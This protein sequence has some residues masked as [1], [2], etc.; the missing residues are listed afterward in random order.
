M[1]GAEALIWAGLGSV[2]LRVAALGR[3]ANRGKTW[4]MV[5]PA[6][7]REV[8]ATKSAFG[9]CRS[10]RTRSSPAYP[11]APTTAT[12]IADERVMR[13]KAE[14]PAGINRRGSTARILGAVNACCIG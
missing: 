7:W 1:V 8:T 12:G 13:F 10:N 4:A 11:E 14:S 5:W 2:N 9:W 6:Y 3:C